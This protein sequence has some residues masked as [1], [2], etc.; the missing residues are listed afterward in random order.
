MA[1][2][3]NKREKA[4]SFKMSGSK[5]AMIELRDVSI[6]YEGK[7][8][9]TLAVDK[10]NFDVYESDFIVLLGPSGCGKSSILNLIAGFH[11]P[12]SGSVKMHGQDITAPGR[13]RGVVFQST[14][15][16]P[17]L[18]VRDNINYGLRINKVKASEIEEKTEVYLEMIGLKDYEKHYPFE[19]SGGMRQRVALA[20]TLI[21]SPEILLM[22]EPLGA[23]DAITRTSMQDFIR[24]LW[25]RENQ[26]FF[27]ITHDIDE[28]LSLGSRVLVMSK[29][30]GRILKEF[31][32]DFHDRI[33]LEPDYTASLDPAYNEVKR[34]VLNLINH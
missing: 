23:L 8:N 9:T 4:G 3:D 20:R 11:A 21:N 17:W 1:E 34:E 2:V 14:N 26:T 7:N 30:P 6:V 5:E 33:Q 31:K 10:V 29:S 12:S 15:L 32:L 22:D 19:L 24:D 25:K 16:F 27:M 18:S 28:A 13:N